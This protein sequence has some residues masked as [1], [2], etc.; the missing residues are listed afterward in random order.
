MNDFRILREKERIIQSPC[1]AKG[2]A[3]RK[4]AC[5]MNTMNLEWKRLEEDAGAERVHQ[6][7]W[8][9]P[10][11][12]T[13]SP[14]EPT[15]EPTPTQASSRRLLTR[16]YELVVLGTLLYGLAGFLIWRQID[17][18]VAEI[19]AE[20]HLLRIEMIESFTT[21]SPAESKEWAAE[22]QP[23]HPPL[24]PLLQSIETQHFRFIFAK[25]NQ[26]AAK[27]IASISKDEL[28]DLHRQLAPPHQ[29]GS[30][31]WIVLLRGSNDPLDANNEPV[32]ET[33]RYD[34]GLHLPPH[35]TERPESE[36]LKWLQEALSE[37]FDQLD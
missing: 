37:Q 27:I 6:S 24:P 2:Y 16:I 36:R 33:L 11:E 5:L 26:S 31:Q 21:E 30:K 4:A 23:I 32:M 12:E 9:R 20:I 7:R 1:R 35:L 10:Q 34:L 22:Q 14:S 19:E 28:A 18:R 17:Q 15:E 29:K 25:N 3:Y 13:L 8:G